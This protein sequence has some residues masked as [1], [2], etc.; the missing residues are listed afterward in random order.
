MFSPDIREVRDGGREF[1]IR[2]ERFPWYFIKLG[3][4]EERK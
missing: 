4:R 2:F 1:G 3:R